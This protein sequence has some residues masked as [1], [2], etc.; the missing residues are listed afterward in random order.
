MPLSSIRLFAAND[1][2]LRIDNPL[3]LLERELWALIF[4]LTR[5]E[6][7]KVQLLQEFYQSDLASQFLS[8]N[9]TPLPSPSYGLK[10][11]ADQLVDMTETIGKE[12]PDLAVQVV[13]PIEEAENQLT[14]KKK[15]KL[16]HVDDTANVD[17]GATTSTSNPPHPRASEAA[18]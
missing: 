15:H 13:P 3:G 1:T 6:I 5:R 18:N 8:P 16:R 4:T 9:D 17:D 14:P 11:A 7:D 2:G 12:Y 10:F